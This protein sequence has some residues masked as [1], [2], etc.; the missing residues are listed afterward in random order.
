MK[1]FFSNKDG[2]FYPNDTLDY[3]KSIGVLPDDLQEVSTEEHDEFTGAN[4]EG[5]IP[6]YNKKMIWIDAPPVQYSPE[7]LTSR[8]EQKKLLL[9]FTA[10]NLITPL[11]DSVDLNIATEA[12]IA[13]LANWKKYRVELSRI[14]TNL[15]P[16]IDWP[17]PPE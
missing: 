13:K 14:D 17:T 16:D 11:Q 6:F 9:M 8:A 1:W 2:G 12:E 4:P 3:C 10:N 7:Q 15:A 5:K